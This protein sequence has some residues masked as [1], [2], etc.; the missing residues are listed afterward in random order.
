MIHTDWEE[1]V[2][3]V[4]A[5][6]KPEEHIGVTSGCFDIVH[7][8][9]IHCLTRCEKRCDI[10]VVLVDSNFLIEKNKPTPVFYEHDR[11]IVINAL[12]AVR[13]ATVIDSLSDLQNTLNSL[14]TVFNKVTLFR[15]SDDVYG[16]PVVQT[17]ANVE[18]V[19]D[20]EV[21]MSSTAI[22][23]HIGERHKR[24]IASL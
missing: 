13:H 19:K 4:N 21:F 3:V 18:Y 17:T 14:K 12:S 16:K 1:L 8:L 5:L 2:C 15:N 7:P 6:Y 11:L 10:L 20:V 9:H 22:K 24:T 23:K